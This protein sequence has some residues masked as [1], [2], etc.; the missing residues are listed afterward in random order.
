MKFGTLPL[1][2]GVVM[3]FAWVATPAGSSAPS[4]P[5]SG[6]PIRLAINE[7]TGQHITTHVAGKILERMGYKVKYVAAGYFPQMQAL[8]DG[9]LSASLEIWSNNIGEHY[10]K[11]QETGKVERIAD[12]GLETRE[13]WLYPKFMEQRCPGLPEWGALRNCPEMFATPETFP[14]GRVLSY[15]PDWGT[16]SADMIRG[17]DLHFVAVPADSESDL[18]AALRRAAQR[19][20]PLLMMFWAPHWVFA[21]VEVGW[22]NLPKWDPRCSEDPSWGPNPGAVNDCGVDTA[23]T[24]KVAWSGM[25]DKWPAAYRFLR[26]F[27]MKDKDQIAM[28]AAIDVRGEDLDEVTEAWV[29]EHE[30]TWKPWVDAAVQ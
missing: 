2:L 23:V 26:A 12:L 19:G 3:A 14:S 10:I 22:V 5:E 20:E 24:F 8:Q 28:M 27:E 21:D 30:D 11:A 15:P 17:L 1:A 29:E 18:V 13:G 9:S 6:D 7:W 4:I 25:K 16:R